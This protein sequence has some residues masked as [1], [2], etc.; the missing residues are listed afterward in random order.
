MFAGNMEVVMSC[1]RSRT[2]AVFGIVL[3][4]VAMLWFPG[5]FIVCDKLDVVLP[6]VVQDF[7]LLGYKSTEVGEGITLLTGTPPQQR[8]LGWE[9]RLVN[10][11]FSKSL[12]KT[13][14]IIIGKYPSGFLRHNGVRSIVVGGSL[15]YCRLSW[16]CNSD[17]AEK[18][19]AQKSLGVFAVSTLGDENLQKLL[20]RDWEQIVHHEIGHVVTGSIDLAAWMRCLPQDVYSQS[21]WDDG[22]VHKGFVSAYARSNVNEDVAETFSVVMMV[23]LNR[24]LELVQDNAI[25]CKISLVGRLFNPE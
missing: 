12:A 4:S 24:A 10:D 1:C 6:E 22:L 7:F 5:F 17:G 16:L 18:G 13:V 8:L 9:M 23:G 3:L 20:R 21:D 14:S 25:K 19:R 11:E 15:R 2:V